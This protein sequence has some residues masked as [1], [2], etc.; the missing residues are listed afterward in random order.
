MS[1]AV[2]TVHFNIIGN[3]SS[4]ICRA[5]LKHEAKVAAL[6]FPIP[7]SEESQLMVK[8]PKKSK[9][10]QSEPEIVVVSF[11]VFKTLE[12]LVHSNVQLHSIVVTALF[13]VVSSE[14]LEDFSCVSRAA[15]ILMYVNLLLSSKRFPL[16]RKFC[17]LGSALK[18]PLMPFGVKE[19]ATLSIVLYLSSSLR[20]QNSNEVVSASLF[21]H[22]SEI[23]IYYQ[24]DT[25]LF[26][27]LDPSNA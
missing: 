2:M 4:S 7:S 11:G 16:I 23:S 15:A 10:N 8:A 3:L 19:E 27:L 26:L 12:I 1:C 5:E 24:P 20:N 18:V 13:H 14:F 9:R 21:S 25:I 6:A 22:L 17:L